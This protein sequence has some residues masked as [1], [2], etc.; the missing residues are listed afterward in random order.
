[1][2]DLTIDLLGRR[3]FRGQEQVDLLP[4]EFSLLEYLVRNRGRVVTRTQIL[5]HVWG[6]NF[7][8]S[9]NVVDVHICR[10]REK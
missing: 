1:V 6:Y 7:N 3:A 10:L 8:P 4:Q 2:S 5:K 9:T